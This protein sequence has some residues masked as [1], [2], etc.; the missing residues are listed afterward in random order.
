MP[1]GGVLRRSLVRALAAILILGCVY[2]TERSAELAV[3][4]DTVPDLLRGEVFQLSAQVMDGSGTALS[5]TDV[6]F[7]SEDP[8]VAT[9]SED[10]NVLAVS[11]GTTGLMASAVGFAEAEVDVRFLRVHELLEVDS[12]RPSLVRFGDTLSIFGAGLNPEQLFVVRLGNAEAPVKSFTPTD[13][14]AP[15]RFGVLTVYVPPPAPPQ[16]QALLL[17]VEGLVT[18]PDTARVLQRDIYEPNDTIPWDFGALTDAIANPAL[19]FEVRPRD[20]SLRFDWYRFSNDAPQDRTIIVRS[21]FVGT[22]S[23]QVFVTDSLYWS[24]G[25]QDFGIGST[26]WTIGPELYA[27]DGIP[28]APPQLPADS[29]VIALQ[30]MPSGVYDVLAGYGIPGPYEFA[31][32]PEYRSALPPDAAEENDI[33]DLAKPFSLADAQDF[34]IDNPRDIDWFTLSVTGAG[35]TV[36]LEVLT[37]VEDADLDLYL[38]RDERPDSLPVVGFSAIGGQS[39]EVSAFLDPGD[40]F[41]VVVDFAGIPT[42]YSLASASGVVPVTRPAVRRS[43]ARVVEPRALRSYRSPR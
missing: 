33:C 19:S 32:L 31:I 39:D 29:V 24:P 6:M 17:G 23:Y 16:T 18:S 1:S 38:L 12:L 7:V 28:F 34:T 2:P 11:A 10:G 27:C 20:D 21:K 36:T 41:L 40:Y 9:V 26:A 30:G 37:E 14:D 22:E 25:V 13:P 3:V 5:N 35:T 42:S 15:N 4:I 8:L 43:R